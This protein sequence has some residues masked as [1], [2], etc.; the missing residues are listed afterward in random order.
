MLFVVCQ[1]TFPTRGAPS[2]GGNDPSS[3]NSKILIA[4]GSSANKLEKAQPGITSTVS[5]EE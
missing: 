5:R 1:Q 4:R 3:M 2:D